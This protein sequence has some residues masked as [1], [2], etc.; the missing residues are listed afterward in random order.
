MT[1]KSIEA[2]L[3]D[4]EIA[5]TKH[6]EATEQ[7]DHKTGNKNYTVI[8]NV[9]TFLKEQNEMER[10]SVFL[11]NSSEGVRLWAATYLLPVNEQQAIGVLEEIAKG[12]GIC[13]FNA[14]ITLSEWRKGDLKL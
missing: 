2:A 3:L 6:A 9:I 11:N 5:A 13:S 1:Y 7:G 12:S 4:L 14:D 8:S 10:L